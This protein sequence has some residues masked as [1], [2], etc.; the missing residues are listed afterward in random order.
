MDSLNHGD[1]KILKEIAGMVLKDCATQGVDPPYMTLVNHY[2]EIAKF[3]KGDIKSLEVH[4][5]HY[6]V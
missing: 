1:V 3:Y 6:V 4:A 2:V 5:N